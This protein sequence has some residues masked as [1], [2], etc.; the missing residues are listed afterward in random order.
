MTSIA[1]H[2]YQ[3]PANL[4]QG[5]VIAIT[6]AGDGIGRSAAISFAAHGATVI[7]LGKTIEK[8]EAVYD[9]IENAGYPQAAIYPLHLGG[10]VMKDYQD[11][12]DTLAEEFGKLDGLLHNASILGD[13][14][15]I[16]QTSSEG[17]LELM[18]INLNAPFMMTQALLP[19]LEQAN[20]AS[21]IF[22]S[23]GV[24][25]KS[26]AYWGGYAVS[27]F[28][29][30]GLMQTLADELA[31]TSNIR[32]NSLNPGATN[33]SMRR[34]A[35]PAEEPGNNPHPDDIM[36]SYLYL[37]GEDSKGVNGQALDAQVKSV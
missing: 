11:L 18:Q 30:E 15:P 19:L 2:Q 35:F 13:R 17:W 10:A 7:L 34:S 9:H 27:K 21:I 4:L 33:T 24:G 36:A 5:R 20:D 16:A 37:M 25:R 1:P 26:R 8:L 22:T 32:A 29:T 3:A 28:A 14:K 23:S 31:N 6:G 12:H